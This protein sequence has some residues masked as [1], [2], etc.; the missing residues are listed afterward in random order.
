MK[1]NLPVP[2]PHHV[3]KFKQLILETQGIELSDREALDQCSNMVQ[4]VFLTDMVLPNLREIKR[5]QEE[6]Q[7]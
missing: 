5:R 3:A 7:K 2:Q 6:G 4:Y 1:I